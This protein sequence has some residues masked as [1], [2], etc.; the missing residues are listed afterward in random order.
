MIGIGGHTAESQQNQSFKGADILSALRA[1]AALPVAE[2]QGDIRVS[3]KLCGFDPFV[4]APLVSVLKLTFVT[5]VNRPSIMSRT[6]SF[7]G[8]F[9]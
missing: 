3:G 5:V 9:P 6:I 4:T 7:D 1:S 8:V 2:I